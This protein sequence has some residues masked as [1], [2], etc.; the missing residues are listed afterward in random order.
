MPNCFSLLIDI[1]NKY[2]GKKVS[3]FHVFFHLLLMA[4]EQDTIINDIQ[5]KRGQLIASRNTLEKELNLSDKS[6]RIALE[7]LI[8]DN[9]VSKLR[10]NKY[11]IITICNYDSYIGITAKQKANKNNRTNDEIKYKQIIFETI[12]PLFKIK[13]FTDSKL[14]KWNDCYRLLVEKDGF[15]HE[16]IIELIT[17]ARNNSFWK[18]NFQSFLKLRSTD[19]YGTKYIDRFVELKNR[20]NA[21]KQKFTSKNPATSDTELASNIAEGIN[22]GIRDKHLQ[23]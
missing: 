13:D 17:W 16:E 18:P 21:I 6:I 19:K 9:Y 15:K 12:L 11:N 1:K 5:V 4:N 7:R 8:I 3:T 2:S 10:A 20:N 23:R 22:R 14:S